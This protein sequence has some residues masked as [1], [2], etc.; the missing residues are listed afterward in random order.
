MNKLFIGLVTIILAAFLIT[1]C[2]DGVLAPESQQSPKTTESAQPSGT[3]N[4]SP[5]PKAE[6]P[7]NKLEE[8]HETI[9]KSKPQIH[10][11]LVSRDN[12]LLFEKYYNDNSD[13]TLHQIRSVTKSFTSALIGIAIQ[14]GFIKDI[15]QKAADYFPDYI[16]EETDP[17]VRDITIRHLLTMTSGIPYQYTKYNEWISVANPIERAF[18]LGTVSSPGERF[19]YNDPAT[20]ILSGILTAA[21]GMQASDF[22]DRYLFQPLQISSYDWPTD[23]QGNNIGAAELTLTSR[24]ML[25]FGQL[26][27][28]RGEWEGKQVVPASWV[29]ESVSAK[30]DGGMPSGGK[31][32]YLWWVSNIG[33]YESF[34]AMGYGGQFIYVVPDLKLV[35]VITSGLS[36]HY[37][38]NKGLVEAYIVPFFEQ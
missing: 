25:K 37:E 12:E 6:A 3:A 17:A 14:E 31:Y 15:D 4:V 35:A 38:E 10:S 26:Y 32:G 24:D 16:T 27:L 22:A 2:S 36:R 1:G 23:P 8:M 28:N 18:G 5:S 20:H 7:A 13:K 21:T 29:D 19:T 34:Y 11:V 9:V 30:T 33:D